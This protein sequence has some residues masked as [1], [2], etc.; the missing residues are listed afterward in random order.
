MLWIE[1]SR[2]ENRPSDAWGLGRSLWSPSRKRDGSRWAFWDALLRVEEGDPVLHLV[3]STNPAFAGL[4][5]AAGDGYETESVPPSGAE[6]YGSTDTFY[7]VHLD[8]FILFES[9]YPL[10]SLFQEDGPWWGRIAAYYRKNRERSRADKRVILPV[11]QGGRLQCLNGAYLSELTEEWREILFDFLGAEEESYNA[12]LH[13]GIPD[14]FGANES[15][16]KQGGET[17]IRVQT[18]SQLREVKQRSGQKE[19]SD[20]VKSNYDNQCCF[21][22]C[23][24]SDARF[25]IGAH[26]ARWSDV[27]ALRGELSNG[28][29]L[30]LMHDKA[31]E[32]GLFTLDAKGRVWF[33]A[34]RADGSD[35]AMRHIEPCHGEAIRQG[36]VEPSL[37]ALQHHW[38]RVRSYPES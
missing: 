8:D 3:G 18:G 14:L 2:N 6:E 4:S 36:D 11:V 26:I 16:S 24:V 10:A 29:C 25:L 12:A 15:H 9:P 13:P 17:V 34:E 30:C 20:E 7:R 38:N 37:Q 27:P 32:K 19:F 5:R 28:L 33:N 21:P 35:W 1:M 22:G 31:F 23:R